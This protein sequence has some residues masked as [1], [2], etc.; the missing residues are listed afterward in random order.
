MFFDFSTRVGLVQFF[1]EHILSHSLVDQAIANGSDTGLDF[2]LSHYHSIQYT[3]DC[4][5]RISAL[6]VSVGVEFKGI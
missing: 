6:V 1:S 3:F 2:H 4:N 5:A